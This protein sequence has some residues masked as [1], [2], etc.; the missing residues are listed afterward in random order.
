MKFDMGRAWNDAVA[1]LRANG[2]VVA[3]IAG[4]FFFLPYLAL[5]LLLPESVAGVE[6]QVAGE[7]DAGAALQAVSTLYARI[8]WQIILVTLLT[9]I[10]MLGLLALL[11]DRGRPTVGEALKSGVAYFLPYLG[12]QILMVLLFFVLILV[13][14]AIGSIGGAAIGALV[15]IVAL[16]AAIYVYVKFSLVIP[17]IVVE[18]IA[19]PVRALGRSWA[20]TKGNSV[21]LFL[22]YLLLLIALLVIAIV[23]GLVVGLLGALAG[24][25]S[26]SLLGAIVNSGINALGIAIYLAVLA[27]IH[28]QLSGGSPEAGE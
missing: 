14:A 27:A 2:Q 25:S 5:M 19:N 12:A 17:V 11:T 23:I 1:L 13:G 24:P 7:R 20:L 8:W 4:V 3:I 22:F 26:A 16:V 10:G 18:R 21:R 15:G 6:A 9:A 28:R